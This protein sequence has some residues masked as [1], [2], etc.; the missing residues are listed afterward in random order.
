MAA[1]S[2]SGAPVSLELTGARL[3]ATAYPACSSG[4][5]G[6]RPEDGS[7]AVSAPSA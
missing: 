3:I 7:S 5:G 4:M 1:V 2:H 6:D